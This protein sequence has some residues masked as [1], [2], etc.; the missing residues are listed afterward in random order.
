MQ[1]ANMKTQ[2][3][4]TDGQVLPEEAELYADRRANGEAVATLLSAGIG[5]FLLGLFT[6]FAEISPGFK[7]WLTFDKG[8]GPLSG[9][10]IIPVVLW[11]VSWIG[12]VV[13][14]KDKNVNF[15]RYIT[16]TIVLIVLG[17]LGTFPIF[18]QLFS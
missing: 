8:V 4:A 16:A 2:R 12:L 17:V 5:V 7:T 18:F 15:N 1:T 9:K 3:P 10:T 11:L 6:T 13:L 14:W